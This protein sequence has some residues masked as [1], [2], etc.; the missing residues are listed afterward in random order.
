M[1]EKY[2]SKKLAL[3]GKPTEL[4]AQIGPKIGSIAGML[5]DERK[6]MTGPRRC[7]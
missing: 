5:K 1:K 7:D 3:S 2:I 6:I 4:S